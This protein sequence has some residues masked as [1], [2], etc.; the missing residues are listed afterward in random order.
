VYNFL[1]IY[2]VYTN[3]LAII[4]IQQ[5]AKIMTTE[6]FKKQKQKKITAI[7]DMVNEV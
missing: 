6:K 4:G 5:T 3:T 2:F 7:I 1:G